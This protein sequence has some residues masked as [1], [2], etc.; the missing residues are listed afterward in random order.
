MSLRSSSRLLSPKAEVTKDLGLAISII[1]HFHV[2]LRRWLACIMTKS[3]SRIS[4][5]FR[6]RA[7]TGDSAR[8]IV[9]GHGLISCMSSRISSQ[10]RT[11]LYCRV[12]G[13]VLSSIL[14]T[15]LT[16]NS[17]WTS[18]KMAP[19]Q[20]RM[21]LSTMK[22]PAFG[23]ISWTKKNRMMREALGRTQGSHQAKTRRLGQDS[24][25]LDRLDE[26]LGDTP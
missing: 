9:P 5:K 19:L 15:I 8:L 21:T 12:V 7:E 20:S 1:S 11:F 17:P 3:C 16:L 4:G 2:I 23:A 24:A 26:K 22:V 6:V 18:T 10:R 25:R 13:A 14:A